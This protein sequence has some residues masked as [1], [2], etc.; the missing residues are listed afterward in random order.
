MK[1]RGPYLKPLR[2]EDTPELEPTYEDLINFL[3][4]VP[5][6]ELTM[7]RKPRSTKALIDFVKALYSS[8]TLPGGLLYLVGLLTSSAAG[9]QYCASHNVSKAEDDGIDAAKIAAV[10][11]FET[12]PLFTD[13]ELPRLPTQ[14]E[15]NPLDALPDA[16]SWAD[17]LALDGPPD[18]LEGLGKILKGTIRCPA[19]ILVHIPMPCGGMADC[20]VCAVRT[21]KNKYKLACVDGPVFDLSE[22]R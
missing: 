14:V 8:L 18:T 11:D 6:T 19:Q 9:C 21:K 7:A 13:A 4:F 16:L 17:F 15:A 22:I 12:S 2:R 10:W 5:N 3:G 20:G 1:T